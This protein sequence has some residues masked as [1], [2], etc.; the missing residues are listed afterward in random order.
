MAELPPGASPPPPLKREPIAVLSDKGREIMQ[1]LRQ[2]LY[3][4]LGCR[5]LS[6]HLDVDDVIRV[7][8][9][10]IP[11]GPISQDSDNGQ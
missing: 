4:P 8:C 2:Q 1:Y 11:K 6:V 5:R 9:S 10:Y 7:D 3:I